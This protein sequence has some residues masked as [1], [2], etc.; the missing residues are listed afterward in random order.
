MLDLELAG[1][2]AVITGAASGIGAACARAFAGQGVAV[3][4]LDRDAA[5]GL[6]ITTKL[7]EEGGE[8]LFLQA[9]VANE[10][11]VAQA[12][13]R[14]LAWKQRIDILVCC[15]G[16]SGPVGQTVGEIAAADW[17]RVMAVNLGGI[18]HCVKHSLAALERSQIG[19]VVILASDSSFLAYPGMAAYSTAKGG[20][21]MLTR[22]LAVD[23]QRLRVN[24][25][26]PSVVDTPMSQRDLGLAADAMQAAGFPV[27]APAQLARQVL[28][29][30]SPVSAPVNGAALV[31]DFG[32]MAR[33]S[34]PQP[35][36]QTSST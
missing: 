10:A 22:A 11:A 16:I 12:M 7:T 5:A 14:A 24:C 32:Y 35:D 18:F 13:A 26:C 21:L 6:I 31:V 28:F 34:F 20:A 2:V 15:A 4:L 29:L 30:A 36:F 1:S 9:D 23:H 33:P 19:S 25:I 27:I 8:A 3:V 17:A